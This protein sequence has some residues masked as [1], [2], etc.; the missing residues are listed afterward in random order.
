ML[1]TVLPGIIDR[2]SPDGLV[3]VPAKEAVRLA[4]R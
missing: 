1:E 2:V 4:S 3:P